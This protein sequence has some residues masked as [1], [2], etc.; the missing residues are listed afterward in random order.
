MVVSKTSCLYGLPA[1]GNKD[2]L[3]LSKNIY[4]IIPLLP[5]CPLTYSFAQQSDVRRTI[6]DEG[7]EE[8]LGGSSDSCFRVIWRAEGWEHCKLGD[9]GRIRM[10]FWSCYL[11][12]F[13]PVT[14]QEMK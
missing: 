10:L 5:Q 2:I 11:Y 14:H 6:W 4:F 3:N 12:H 9:V 8:R 1:H 13:L 7:V